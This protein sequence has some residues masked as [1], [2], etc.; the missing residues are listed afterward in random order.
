VF[1]YIVG[2]RVSDSGF[3]RYKYDLSIANADG[4]N[5][6]KAPDT[7]DAYDFDLSPDGKKTVFAQ[8]SPIENDQCEVGCLPFTVLKIMDLETGEVTTLTDGTEWIG[9]PAWRP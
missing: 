9:D 7:N 8:H 6:Q 5:D 4:T 1:I 3:V 2:T